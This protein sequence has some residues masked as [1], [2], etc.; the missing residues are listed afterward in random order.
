MGSVADWELANDT[1]FRVESAMHTCGNADL[2]CNLIDG[3]FLIAPKKK[4]TCDNSPCSYGGQA[5]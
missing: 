1:V 5:Q 2:K 3:L 4:I